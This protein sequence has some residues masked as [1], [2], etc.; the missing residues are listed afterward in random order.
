MKS[1]GDRALLASKQLSNQLVA[2]QA[3][4]RCHIAEDSRE[5]AKA[6]GVVIRYGYVMLA[7]LLAGQAHMAS[8]LPRHAVA[9]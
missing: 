6:Q 8:G 9:E 5:S 7:R 4:M 2:R 1:V 3:V